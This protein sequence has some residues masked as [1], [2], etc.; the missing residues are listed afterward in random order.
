MNRKYS[1]ITI[2]F[3]NAEGLQ[4]TLQSIRQLQYKNYELIVVDGGSTDA[5][6]QVVDAEKDIIAHFVSEKDNGVYDAMNKGLKLV[7]GNYVVFMNAGDCFAA[8]DTLDR[9]NRV[10]TDIIL[11]SAVYGGVLRLAKPSMTLYDILSIGINHQSTYYRAGIIKAVGF[12]CGYTI[13]AD[14]KSVVAP[15]VQM[16]ASV[17]CMDDVLSVCEGG[18]MSQTRWRE[19][20]AERERMILELMPQMYAKDYARMAR[21]NHSILPE[22]TVLSQ[23]STLYPII[24]LL[25]RFALWYNKHFKHIPL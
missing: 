2:T 23:F 20:P 9:V 19:I 22:L 15:L 4:R 24:R 17:G 1:I 21:L 5:T 6:A 3:N 25:S 18:G 16:G 10:D 12:D 13:T 8:P 11:G 7:S 14:L